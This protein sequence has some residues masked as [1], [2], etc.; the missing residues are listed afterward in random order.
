[1][2]RGL[3]WLAKYG[4]VQVFSRSLRVSE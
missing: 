2:E 1:V 4:I 3:L